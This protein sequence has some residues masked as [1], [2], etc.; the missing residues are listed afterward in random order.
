MGIYY[1]VPFYSLSLEFESN[2]NFAD[3]YF[4]KMAQRQ[5]ESQLLHVL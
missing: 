1:I 4:V 3:H 5:P 2:C